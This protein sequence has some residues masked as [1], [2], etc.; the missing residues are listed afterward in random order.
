MPNKRAEPKKST[1]ATAEPRKAGS[2]AK[3]FQQGAT[4]GRQRAR[5][6]RDPLKDLFNPGRG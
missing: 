3:E 5:E 2:A 6:P 1:K 4:T